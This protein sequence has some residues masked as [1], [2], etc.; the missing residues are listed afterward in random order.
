M[1]HL[2]SGQLDHLSGRK[3]ASQ[4]Y[5][6]SHCLT[7]HFLHCALCLPACNDEDLYSSEHLPMTDLLF[8][9]PA[10]PRLRCCQFSVSK[11]I[12]GR[13]PFSQPEER[14]PP[15]VNNLRA[16]HRTS[17]SQ[18]RIHTH[19]V[20]RWLVAFWV[21]LWPLYQHQPIERFLISG[22]LAGTPLRDMSSRGQW[23][24]GAKAMHLL[25]NCQLSG[26]DL[27]DSLVWLGILG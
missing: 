23:Q 10:Q 27:M 18:R 9:V 8:D 15:L 14:A 5:V 4:C 2:Q 16:Y 3:A 6:R 21:D 19:L 13:H 25:L 24:G 12:T 7:Y 20:T 11:S 17:G 22:S 26:C 1:H